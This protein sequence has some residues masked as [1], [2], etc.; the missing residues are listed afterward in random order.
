M[1]MLKLKDFKAMEIKNHELLG[2]KSISY[3]VTCGEDGNSQYATDELA[4]TKYADSTEAANDGCDTLSCRDNEYDRFILKLNSLVCI[5]KPSFNIL[6]KTIII[7]FTLFGYLNINIVSGQEIK[8]CIEYYKLI[9]EA[10]ENFC[11][12]KYE[13]GS[14]IYENAISSS[15][16]RY[17]DI[18]NYA[19]CKIASQKFD[20]MALRNLILA[21]ANMRGP[22]LSYNI[23]NDSLLCTINSDNFFQNLQ[24]IE[25]TRKKIFPEEIQVLIDLDQYIRNGPFSYETMNSID[26]MIPPSQKSISRTC[27]LEDII[28]R[29]ILLIPVIGCFMGGRWL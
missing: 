10:E 20:T 26:S 25:S 27:R 19:R 2:G 22:Y 8:N 5:S 18:I 11:L 3:S 23:S 21:N 7:F 14:K 16:K 15:F 13:E 4:S 6:N 29:Y 12:Q 24:D 1:I 28:L 9:N 17:R